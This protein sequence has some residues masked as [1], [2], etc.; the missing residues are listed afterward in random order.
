MNFK[1]QWSGRGLAYTP[2]EIQTVVRVMKKADPLTQGPFLSGFEKKFSEQHQRIPCFGVTN[3]AHALELCAV[4]SRIGPGDEVIIPAHTYCASAIPFGRTGAKIVWADIDPKTWVVCAKSIHKLLTKKT[5]VIVAVHL[6]GLM[7]DMVAIRSLAKKNNCLV[8]EDC[9]QALG[10]S[11]KGQK[12]GTLGDFGCF[13]F[14][15]QKNITT[16][17]EGG[18]LLVKSKKLNPLV[19]GL[20]H[21][22]HAP[23]KV[24]RPHYWIPAMT[25]VD[26]DLPGIWPFN[27]SLGEVQAALAN[28]LLD[29]VS[30]IT[31][32]RKKRALRF[33][34]ALAEFPE[35]VFQKIP[36]GYESAWHLLPARYDGGPRQRTRDEL[37]S[38]MA[39][40]YKIKCIVQYCPLY[41]YS[42]FQKF[43][44]SGHNCLNTDYF[45][46]RMISFP[47]SPCMKE[48]DF[49]YVIRCLRESLFILRKK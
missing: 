14:H 13:S 11:L 30:A 34:A 9:A 28:K 32:V 48:Q 39:Y 42:L 44:L 23:F 8:V 12:A 10:A 25:N 33:R 38:L 40:K 41:R 17:G 3:C 31:S 7:A 35:L 22:G 20:R 36:N 18:A 2:A 47:F 45:Y 37:I 6:Y 24:G 21:N 49:R 26:R 43:G 46:D 4:L 29:R 16:L 15:A 27:F 5:K 1:V 19:P